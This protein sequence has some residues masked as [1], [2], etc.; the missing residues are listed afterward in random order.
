MATIRVKTSEHASRWVGLLKH[1]LSR[2]IPNKS[3]DITTAMLAGKQHF[4]LADNRLKGHIPGGGGTP[5]PPRK[6]HN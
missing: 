5:P 1:R 2:S 4:V 3:R 6:V